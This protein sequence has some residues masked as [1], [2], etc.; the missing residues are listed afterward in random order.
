MA[1]NITIKIDDELARAAKVY[2]AQH[3]T[4][5]SRLVTEQLQREVLRDRAFVSAKA[6]ALQ[7]LE[8]ARPLG[9]EKPSSRDELHAR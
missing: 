8:S 5:L 9:W 6:R 2:A 7:R 1:T 3:G 4:S